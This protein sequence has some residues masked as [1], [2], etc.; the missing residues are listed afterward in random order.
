M[1]IYEVLKRPIDTEKTRKQA[2][3]GHYTFEVDRRA[4]KLQVKRAVEEA[5]GVDVVSVNIM[6]VPGKPR[7]FGRHVSRTPAWKKAVVTVAWGQ[8][9]EVFEGV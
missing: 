4:N 8:R 6:N 3:E 5:F 1:H 2:E 9:I 7:R